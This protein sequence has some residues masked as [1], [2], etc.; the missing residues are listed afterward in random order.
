MRKKQYK[1]FAAIHLGSEMISMQIVQYRNLNNMKVLEEC[2]RRV[3]LGEETFKNKI[4]PFSMVNEICELLV[5]FKRLMTEYEVEEYSMQATTAVREAL[6]RVFLLDQIYI[7]T[8]LKVTV[9]DLPEEIYTKYASI[10]RTMKLDG[11]TGVD[12]SMLMMDISSGGLGITF[13]KDNIIRYQ[14]NLNIGVIRVMMDISSGGLGITFVKDN[15]I[16]YQQN[17]NI[18]VIRVKESF[19]RNQRSSMKFNQALAEYLSSTMGAVRDALKNEQIHYLVLTGAESELLL[20]MMGVE[21]KAGV[22]RI[23]TEQFMQLFKTVHELNLPQIIKVFKINEDVAEL[24]V[25]TILLYEQ[26][27]ALVPVQEIILTDDRFIDGICLLHIGPKAS[28]DYAD[29]LEQEQL[30]LLYSIGERYQYDEAH[31]L[32]VAKLALAMF[33]KLGKH[34][35]LDSHS[36]ILLQATALLHDIGKYVS[37]RSHSLYSYMLIMSCDILGFSEMDKKIVAL[38]SYYHAHRLFSGKRHAEVEE[39]SPEIMPLVA[40]IAALVR[41]ADAMDRSYKQK[42]KSCRVNVKNGVMKVEAVTL[43]DL[44]IEEWTFASKSSFF[45]E[46]YGLQA[47]LERV[48]R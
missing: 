48:D 11:L 20:Q 6:N 4:I 36:R 15:I 47:V 28:K 34:H 26:L 33:D 32:Q 13:V 25:P 10:R 8:G 17:L 31:S 23:K 39:M 44:T 27:L 19:N 12:E 21:F 18:G 40:K 24:V 46:V 42:I 2:N 5:G 30:S 1:I 45:E 14:Q 41:L 38:A 3:R 9:I 29:E 37:L 35:G 7:R 22:I 16:R 43:E